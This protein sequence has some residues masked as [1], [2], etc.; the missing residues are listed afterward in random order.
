MIDRSIDRV[1]SILSIAGSFFCGLGLARLERTYGPD[2]SWGKSSGI[3][4]MED[5]GWRVEWF[6]SREGKDLK[7]FQVFSMCCM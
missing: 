2:L 4:N 5:G 1:S 6:G 3:F 7:R